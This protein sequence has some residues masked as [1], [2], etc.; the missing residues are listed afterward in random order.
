M[1]DFD[2]GAGFASSYADV[3]PPPPPVAQMLYELRPL[4][5][6]EILDRTFTIYRARIWL[7]VGLASVA[8][9]I[10]TLDT[11]I[12]LTWG[13]ASG[14]FQGA[15]GPR[16]ALIYILS[17]LVTSIVYVVAYSITQ[18][19]TVSAVSS[20]YLGHET[21]IRAAFRV[22]LKHWFRYIL[23]TLWQVWSALWLPFLLF[24][25]AVVLL[26]VAR[27]GLTVVGGI[28]MVLAVLGLLYGIYAYLRNSLGIVASVVENLRVRD[29]MRR[30]K[31]IVDGRLGRVV[32]ILLIM[33]VL[34]L[35][36]G[37]VQGIF[38]IF[39]LRSHAL[40]HIFWEALTLISAFLT[41]SMVAPVG[42]I[43]F[44]LFYIDQ[45][46][47]KEGFDVETLMA[48]ALS[49]GIPLVGAPP[50]SPAF[51]APFSP[52]PPPSASSQDSPF[53]SSELF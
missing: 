22:A 34:S 48:R 15:E 33:W 21:S 26:A 46:V 14:R 2:S 31:A 41:G 10:T 36:A 20:V 38:A 24:I 9:T 6:G 53:R 17:S 19:A 13:L 40:A 37:V 12:R 18:A 8:A 42:A 39:L 29:A 51:D 28:L 16:A 35:V 44:V 7:F 3:P 25:P 45:R 11:F 43:A 50:R 47:R 4:S 27:L 5:I 23:I 52:V 32:A 1:P 30:S 49:S